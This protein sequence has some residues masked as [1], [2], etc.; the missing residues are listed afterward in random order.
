MRYSEAV[1]RHKEE[2]KQRILDNILEAAEK[3]KNAPHS[4]DNSGYEITTNETDNNEKETITM[5]ETM[6]NEVSRRKTSVIA[7]AC[8]ALIIG[9]GAAAFTHSGQIQKDDKVSM[10]A[11]SAGSSASTT[12]LNGSS[13]DESIAQSDTDESITDEESTADTDTSSASDSKASTASSSDTSSKDTSSGKPSTTSSAADTSSGNTVTVSTP[14]VVTSTPDT[15]A[16]E[17]KEKTVPDLKENFD[18][19]LS[20]SDRIVAGDIVEAEPVIVTK[21]D[22]SKV[23][24]IK[25]NIHGDYVYTTS[26]DRLNYADEWHTIIYQ[27]VAEG[28]TSQ[29]EYSDFAVFM[30]SDNGGINMTAGNGVFTYSDHKFRSVAGNSG[31]INDA[32]TDYIFNKVLF[33]R[34]FN[35]VQNWVHYYLNEDYTIE[36]I[37][38]DRYPFE[39]S[40]LSWDESRGEYILSNNTNPLH[41]KIS[42]LLCGK[43]DKY[44]Q[45]YTAGTFGRYDGSELEIIDNA[46]PVVYDSDRFEIVM[47]STYIN[48]KNNVVDF[49]FTIIPKEGSGIAFNDNTVYKINCNSA[50]MLEDMGKY[51]NTDAIIVSD[52][53]QFASSQDGS[54]SFEVALYQTNP[55]GKLKFDYDK[56]FSFNI[57]GITNVDGTPFINDDMQIN[58][59]IDPNTASFT[60]ID[61]VNIDNG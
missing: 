10:T 29:L 46:A 53:G 36:D 18:E 47:D 9:C 20:S 34:N 15:S 23:Y 43:N 4:F 25:Y 48:S 28:S 19:L 45:Y 26:T 41:D 30:V 31:S 39:A 60:G 38:D 2:T 54:I 8:A 50:K 13:S 14:D 12:V 3:E 11:A 56:E 42:K 6:F 17:Q 27:P 49:Y 24:C 5:K 33:G 44:F 35:I 61:M 55:N 22:G 51:F 1:K 58:F 59:K 40:F 52:G 21:P 32:L 7:A 16:S 37:A 57:N